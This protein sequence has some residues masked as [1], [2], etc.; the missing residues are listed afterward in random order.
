MNGALDVHGMVFHWEFT[1]APSR[2]AGYR[3]RVCFGELGIERDCPVRMSRT[4]AAK[5]ALRL[6]EQVIL[7]EDGAPAAGEEVRPSS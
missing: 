3:L 1:G 6:A 2:Q 5:E 7:Q 4:T